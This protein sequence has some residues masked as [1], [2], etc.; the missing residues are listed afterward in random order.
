MKILFGLLIIFLLVFA[1]GCDTELGHSADDHD[2]DGD[3]MP[4]HSA[5][6]HDA[7]IDSVMEEG[8]DDEMWK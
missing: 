6:D 4:D 5:E 7:S 2:H 1:V 8:S 3:G